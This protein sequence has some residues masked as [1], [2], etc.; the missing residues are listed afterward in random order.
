M[1]ELLRIAASLRADPSPAVLCTL[2][3]VSGSSFRTIGARMLWRP[4]GS[5][6]GSISGGCLEADLMEQARNVLATRRPRLAH[7]NTAADTDVI[8]GTGSGCEGTIAVWLEPI[9]GLPHW[10]AFI[11]AAWDRR[12]DAALFIE[13]RY[14]SDSVPVGAIAGRT[15]SGQTW[16][17]PGYNNPLPL[18]SSLPAVLEKQTSTQMAPHLSEGHFYEFLPPPPSL[19]I[20]GAGDDAQSLSRLA[21]ELG[22]RITVIDS[23]ADLLNA[24]RFPSA[25]VLHLSPP[26]ATL[27]TLPLDARSYVVAMTHRYLDDLP[28]LRQLLPRPLAYLGLLGSRKRSE[29]ILA[30]LASE[31]LAI[32]P[33]MRARLHAPVGLDLGGGT[34]EEVALAILAEIQAT[35]S[36]R[37][38]RPLRQRH[39]PI[40]HE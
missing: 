8:W 21:A 26:E 11:L 40:H 20:F 32:T 16:S 35:R 37:D 39:R 14:P 17:A 3:G 25:H 2:V 36:A 7:Y 4:D 29:K 38:A 12:E 33:E 27:A 10:L 6:L 18:E 1:K 24:A 15:S 13:C 9:A 28:I 34:P 22:W 5:R 23:R 19:T 30:D 31:G